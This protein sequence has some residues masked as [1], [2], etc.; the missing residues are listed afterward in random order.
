VT[1]SESG[2][3]PP[4]NG[5]GQGGEPP[6]GGQGRWRG[7]VR[8]GIAEQT[9]EKLFGRLP[10]HSEEAEI[11]LLGSVM[12]DPSVIGDIISLVSTPEAFYSQR[13]GQVFKAML[14][15][16]NETHTIDLIPLAELLRSRG[17]V[18]E[19]ETDFLVS[20][21]EAVPSARNAAHYAKIVSDRSR[22]RR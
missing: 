5:R 10:P 7:K 16:H 1:Q 19:E 21:A 11:A 17:V 3:E 20:L 6:E 8:A 14:D 2:S 13:N 22:L 15:L 9:L 12:L 4:Q 18:D